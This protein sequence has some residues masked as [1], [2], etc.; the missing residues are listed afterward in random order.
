M[1]WYETFIPSQWG[2]IPILLLESNWNV[3]KELD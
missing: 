3:K 2:L 1:I